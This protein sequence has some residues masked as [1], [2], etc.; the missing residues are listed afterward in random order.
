MQGA[1]SSQERSSVC[2]RHLWILCLPDF[3]PF[4][5][6]KC[7]EFCRC[8]ALRTMRASVAFVP[9]FSRLSQIWAKISVASFTAIADACSQILNTLCL[10]YG[11]CFKKLRDFVTPFILLFF[12]CSKFI[13]FLHFLT[14]VTEESGQ[15]LCRPL[16]P[17]RATGHIEVTRS[18]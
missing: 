1:R 2:Q 16:R 6:V 17:W 7:L 3:G 12:I 18:L 13:R 4:D 5:A 10:F 15:K 8:C 11:I 9:V 14:E